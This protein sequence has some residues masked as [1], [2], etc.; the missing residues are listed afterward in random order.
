MALVE[1]VIGTICLY[2]RRPERI[3]ILFHTQA[4]VFNRSKQSI[5][6][7]LKLCKC[8]LPSKRRSGTLPGEK[9]RTRYRQRLHKI[10]CI[11]TGY[12]FQII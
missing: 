5:I 3:T 8:D 2:Q 4:A 12:F 1:E 10:I 6:Y 7:D 9:F 11:K